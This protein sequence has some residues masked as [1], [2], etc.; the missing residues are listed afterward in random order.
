MLTLPEVESLL[1][2]G[3]LMVVSGIP[4][5]SVSISRAPPALSEKL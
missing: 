1:D 4:S 2:A 5:P 3:T